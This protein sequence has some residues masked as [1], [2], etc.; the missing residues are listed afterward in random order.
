MRGVIIFVVTGLLLAGGGEPIL[1]QDGGMQGPPPALVRVDVV[2]RQT[3]QQRRLLTGSIKAVRRSVVASE[4]SG[5]VVQAPP[6]P[7]TPVK[8]GAVLVKLDDALLRIQRQATDHAT[9]AAQATVQQ[10]QAE[11]QLAERQRQRRE[12]LVARGAINE[13]ELDDARDDEAGALAALHQAQALV[14]QR[15][16]ELA[17]Y[18]ERLSNMTIAAPFD[19]VVV[20]K[21]TEIG[22][23][24]AP[25]DTVA[26]VVETQRVDAVLDVPELMVGQLAAD[27]PVTLSIEAVGVKRQAPVYR[28]V[29]EGDARART[30]PVLIRLDN[31]EAKL[32]VGMTVT[33]ELPTGQRVEALTV[34]RDA[35]ILRPMGTLVYVQRG[36]V[37]APVPVI[38]HFGAGDRYV[39]DGALNPDEQ[40]V[41]EGNE[42]LFPG[43]PLNIVGQGAA[44]AEDPPPAP[45]AEPA[46]ATTNAP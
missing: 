21:S 37:A 28:I 11:L 20:A 25:G 5:R 9:G 33:A 46:A 39:V 19:G 27:E 35:V 40:V 12:E 29:P 15:Q 26:E 3:V 18:D 24:L 32:K 14:R 43:Q 6:D 36:G 4:E 42:R 8:A 41:V 7:G 31:P 2:R 17:E 34:P 45:A 30:F 38:V 1:A 22:Q 23:W 10:R 13:K 44:P 16:S